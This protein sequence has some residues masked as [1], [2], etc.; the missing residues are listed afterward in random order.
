PADEGE[1]LSGLHREVDAAEDVEAIVRPA[2]ALELHGDAPTWRLSRLRAHQAAKLPRT[3]MKSKT[4]IRMK[5]HTTAEVVAVAIPSVPRR[6]R[7][8]QEPGTIEA[9]WPQSRA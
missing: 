3:I 4:R 8:P 2:H 1:Q 9:P 7:S 6:V 5:L